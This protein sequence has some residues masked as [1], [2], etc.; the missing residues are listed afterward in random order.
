VRRRA[1][2]RRWTL[3]GGAD[4][5]GTLLLDVAVGGPPCDTVTAVDVMETARRA[6]GTRGYGWPYPEN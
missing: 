1:G 6:D 5:G 2:R 3:A 4:G